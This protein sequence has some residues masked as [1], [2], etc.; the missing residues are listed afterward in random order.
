MEGEEHYGAV[1]QIRHEVVVPT[2]RDGRVQEGSSSLSGGRLHPVVVTELKE[3]KKKSHKISRKE[4]KPL[5][6]Y[7]KC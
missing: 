7:C 4:R 6:N 2:R 5:L 3:G 1:G